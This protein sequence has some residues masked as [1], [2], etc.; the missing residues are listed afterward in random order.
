LFPLLC[1]SYLEVF[2]EAERA[3]PDKAARTEFLPPRYE[4]AGE[5]FR[6]ERAFLRATADGERRAALV[7]VG[8][9]E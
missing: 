9:M 1:R 6:V 7:C 3:A 5:Q 2:A 4:A 8:G